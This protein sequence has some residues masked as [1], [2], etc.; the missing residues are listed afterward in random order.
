M[1]P[2]GCWA[3]GGPLS[4]A[5]GIVCFGRSALKNRARLFCSASCTA[6]APDVVSINDASSISFRIACWR[7]SSACHP[8]ARCCSGPFFP[9]ALNGARFMSS[10][11][12]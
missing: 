3:S 1:S 6:V 11:L 4:E 5:I 2:Q 8:R 9:V 10:A 12:A 7:A